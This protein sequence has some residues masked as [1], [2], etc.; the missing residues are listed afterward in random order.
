MNLP[1]VS[2]IWTDLQ[3]FGV[4]GG[5]GFVV[6]ASVL[7]SLVSMAHWSPYS[8]RVL[9]FGLAV[10]VTFILNRLWT[11][12]HRRISSKRTAYTRYFLV[13]VIGALFNLAV[14]FVCVSLF[15]VLHYWPIIALAIGSIIA[16]IFTFTASRHLVFVEHPV[17]HGDKDIDDSTEFIK[18]DAIMTNDNQTR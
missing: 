12:R 9:S 14:F 8:A 4:V 2:R 16:L 6:D 18:K 11:F 1:P 5:I 13:Q 3:R 17:W 7:Q 10:T 15:P